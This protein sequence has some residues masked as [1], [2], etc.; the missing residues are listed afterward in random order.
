[1]AGQPVQRRQEQGGLANAGVPSE[2]RRRT[3]VS[4]VTSWSFTGREAPPDAPH[5]GRLSSTFAS[6]SSRSEL[7]APQSGHFPSHFAVW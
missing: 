2:Q 5:A 6:A 3:S 1:V 4:P 7:Q